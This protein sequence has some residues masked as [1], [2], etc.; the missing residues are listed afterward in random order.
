[1]GRLPGIAILLGLIAAAAWLITLQFYAWHH[2]RASE[3][4][5]ARHHYERAL[6]HAQICR[7]LWTKDPDALWIAA[8]AARC[9]GLYA[10]AK[11][12]LRQYE[13]VHGADERLAFEQLLFRFET[14]EVDAS[15]HLCQEMLDNHNPDA[16]IVLESTVRAL[17]RSFRL[18]AADFWLKK[19]LALEPENVQA[20]CLRG[21][22]YLCG[23]RQPDAL[24]SY[25][26]A[27]QLD[28]E[29]EESRISRADI[30]LGMRRAGEAR[31]DLE[32]LARTR[33]DD[34]RMPTRLAACL[35]LLGQP[36]SARQL[37]DDVLKRWP[38]EA[39]ALSDR[40][41]LA[42][43]DSEYELGEQLARRALE[44]KPGDFTTMFRLQL[45]LWQNGKVEEARQLK[46]KVR[47]AE[48]DMRRLGEII[49]Q[50]MQ[51]KPNDPDLLFEI[52]QIRFREG[53]INES[54]R[55]L[56]N[57]LKV[58]PHH[59]G[60]NIAIAGYYRSTGNTS[61]AARHEALAGPEPN[62]KR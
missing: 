43:E 50:D 8:R 45:C 36:Q 40:A 6:Q 37:L 10:Q 25:S 3:K 38:N 44:K 41:R 9:Q 26:R 1:M 22:L 59:R 28:P 52:A 15:L 57:T 53:A 55:W 49:S 19:W 7:R 27:L 34:P 60:A 11:D 29:H 58:D 48:A 32:I 18:P 24:T 51:A 39:L 42:L 30:L 16:P 54:L 4:A 23:E 12:L 31:A 33:P 14:A 61:L 20:L 62:A 47:K 46:D 13:A 17:L 56:N 21:D 35:D 5:L 2:F